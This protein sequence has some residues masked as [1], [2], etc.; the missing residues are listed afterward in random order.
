MVENALGPGSTVDG[1]RFSSPT[2]GTGTFKRA[3]HDGQSWFD[4]SGAGLT[5]DN[6]DQLGPAL[7][8]AEAAYWQKGADELEADIHDKETI[9]QDNE[10]LSSINTNRALKNAGPSLLAQESGERV[11]KEQ[12]LRAKNEMDKAAEEEWRAQSAGEEAERLRAER[13]EDLRRARSRCNTCNGAA[14]KAKDTGTSK[15]K[16]T[17]PQ[18]APQRNPAQITPRQCS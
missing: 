9:V 10:E 2:Y 13:D 1:D 4:F 3:Y 17:D 11:G 5:K 7:S 6:T 12:A 18:P 16:K 15:I 14:T 8:D